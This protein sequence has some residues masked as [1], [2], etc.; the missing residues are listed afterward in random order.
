MVVIAEVAPLLCACV[1]IVPLNQTEATE[2]DLVMVTTVVG[3]QECICELPILG[4]CEGGRGPVR[5]ALASNNWGNVIHGR[6]WCW[7]WL[8]RGGDALC[9]DD[10]RGGLCK[11]GGSNS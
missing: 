1:L 2:G 8:W 4:Q 11:G 3:Q 6:D 10:G 7:E 9:S 5:R